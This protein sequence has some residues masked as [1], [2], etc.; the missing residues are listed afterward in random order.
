MYL[1]CVGFSFDAV[2]ENDNPF[3]GLLVDVVEPD[4][5]AERAGLRRGDVVLQVNGMRTLTL[6]DLKHAIR[7]QYPGACL[8]VFGERDSKPLHL[9]MIIGAKGVPDEHV[10]QLRAIIEEAEKYSQGAPIAHTPKNVQH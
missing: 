8:D 6:P 2:E 7:N 3:D 10:A 4:T 5:P 9:A 1:C